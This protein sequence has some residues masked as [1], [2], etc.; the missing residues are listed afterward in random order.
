MVSDRI[1]EV[2][3]WRQWNAIIFKAMN[4]GAPKEF[5]KTDGIIEEWMDRYKQ[6][7]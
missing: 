7:K 5:L 4:L 2:F 6:R 1:Q 3:L